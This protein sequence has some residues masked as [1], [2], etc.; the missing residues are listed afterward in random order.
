MAGR[1]LPELDRAVRRPRGQ[2]L[3]VGMK[4]Q[5]GDAALMP[6]EEP[7]RLSPLEIPEP[8]GPVGAGRGEPATVGAVGD[9][10]HGG[11]LPPSLT[12]LGSQS[13]QR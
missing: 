7:L 6:L 5:R 4:V 1:D 2:E 10:E 3:P 13:F 9:R 11:P 8:D 12:S